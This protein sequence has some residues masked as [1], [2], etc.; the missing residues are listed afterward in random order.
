MEK[1][2]IEHGRFVDEYKKRVL[3]FIKQHRELIGHAN[4]TVSTMP[5]MVLYE[6]IAGGAEQLKKEAR[7]TVE[8]F[9]A[10]SALAFRLLPEESGG[11]GRHMVGYI[12][13][14]VSKLSGSMTA[15][16]VLTVKEICER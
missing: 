12:E 4:P 1:T 7:T 5:S 9:E 3:S 11:D 8:P 15:E 13:Q 2:I 6:M 10:I 16:D 14:A